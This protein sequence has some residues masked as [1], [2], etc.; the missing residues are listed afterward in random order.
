MSDQQNTPGAPARQ[1]AINVSDFVYAATGARERRL[2]MPDGEHWFPAADVCRELGYSTT[3]KALLDHVPEKH[4]VSLETVTGGHGLSI[5]AGRSWRRDLQMIDLQGLILLVQGCTKPSCL[6]FKEWVTDVITTLQRDGSYSLNKAEV[7]PTNPEAPPAYAM[8]QQVADAI[9]RLEERNLRTDEEFA[10]AQRDANVMRREAV[11]SL[12]DMATTQRETVNALKGVAEAQRETTRALRDLAEAQQRSTMAMHELLAETVR[13][14][15]PKP[16]DRIPRQRSRPAATAVEEAAAEAV[17]TTAAEQLLAAWRARVTITEDVWA[18][19]VLLAPR[20]AEDG[21][22]RVRVESIAEQ[23][24]LT[25]ARVHDSLRFLL[26]R[27]CIRQ[28]GTRHNAPVY[29]VHHA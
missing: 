29:A 22:V 3:H 24:D 27:Q 18:V 10:L 23:P 15:L 9:V 2:T 6:P 28:V 20:L 1:D 4:R 19:A 13:S 8:P 11:N 25:T 12:R 21:E 5:P 7:Q 14:S 17:E 16:A 26:K